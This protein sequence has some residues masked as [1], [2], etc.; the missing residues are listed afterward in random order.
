MAGRRSTCPPAGLDRPGDDA[1]F[2][3][4]IYDAAVSKDDKPPRIRANLYKL[5][6]NVDQA[7][8]LE[9]APAALKSLPNFQPS[10]RLAMPN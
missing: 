7:K 9:L 3:G 6:G 8:V 1:L 2:G 4:L 10:V 5:T